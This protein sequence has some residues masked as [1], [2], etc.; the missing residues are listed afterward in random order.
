MKNNKIYITIIVVILVAVI[1]V[2]YLFWDDIVV[3]NDDGNCGVIVKEVLVK[4]DDQFTQNEIEDIKKSLTCFNGA[5]IDCSQ[6]SLS[7]QDG[8]VSESLN[9]IT[10]F[11]NEDTTCSVSIKTIDQKVTCPLP[12]EYLV[13]VNRK[14]EENEFDAS[15]ALNLVKDVNFE[16]TSG[17]LDGA[18]VIE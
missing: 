2:F 13:E 16:I 17:N 15:I 3:K 8:D 5:L 6:I 1:G 7:I 9:T 12:P 11:Q 10:I 14:F 18:C 4:E